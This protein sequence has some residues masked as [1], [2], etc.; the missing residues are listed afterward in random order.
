M[1]IAINLTRGTGWRGL[2]VL[3]S[4]TIVRPLLDR[5]KADLMQYANERQLEWRE[6]STNADPKYLRN[7]LR[8]KLTKLDDSAKETLRA[9][10]DRQVTLRKMI[11]TEIDTA[12]QTPGSRYFFTTIPSTVAIELLRAVLL[13]ETGKAPIRPQLE[14]ALL[15]IKTYQPGKVFDIDA[16]HILRFSRTNFVV[17]TRDEVV[18]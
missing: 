3:D 15:A 6:D 5:T 2:A 1:T 17:A 8:Q 13:K 12:I 16:T 14:R 18:S 11:D 9:Y 4:P 10:R 7:G